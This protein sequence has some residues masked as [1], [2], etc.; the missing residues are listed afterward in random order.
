MP[1]NTTVCGIC[2]ES[3]C[4]LKTECGHSF[5]EKCLNQWLKKKNTCPYCT[6]QVLPIIFSKN[7]QLKIRI[8]EISEIEGKLMK[9]FIQRLSN[10][11]FDKIGFYTIDLVEKMISLGFEID[12]EGMDK[13]F[14]NAFASE[15]IDVLDLLKKS[16][17][18]PKM[19]YDDDYGYDPLAHSIQKYNLKMFHW[20]LDFLEYCNGRISGGG[21]IYAMALSFADKTIAK[22][23]YLSGMRVNP[24]E[25][26]RLPMSFAVQ[27]GDTDFLSF[28]LD[29]AADPN[30]CDFMKNY[31]IHEACEWHRPEMVKMLIKAKADLNV[32][33]DC[34][35]TPLIISI[36]EN[37]NESARILI[38][39]GADLNMKNYA[40]NTALH[41]VSCSKTSK[42]DLLGHLIVYGA[43]IDVINAKKETPLHLA[44]KAGNFKAAELLLECGAKTQM[45][46]ENGKTAEEIA[47]DT[48]NHNILSLF[49]RFK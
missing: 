44:V 11:S 49:K 9:E 23:L 15:R 1:N 21:L 34:N 8:K 27:T 17:Y 30:L 20:L 10:S 47:Q 36:N 14:L 48:R 4:N 13:I 25:R 18:K 38:E 33:N 31:P 39:S 35:E 28:L 40:G 22:R 45:K 46:D 37:D 5:H 32:Q 12:C 7:L 26:V 42:L 19:H 24:D 2:R 41:L 6:Q 3:G 43:K 16:G 29:N